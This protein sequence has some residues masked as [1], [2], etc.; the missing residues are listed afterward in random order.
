MKKTLPAFLIII[1]GLGIGLFFGAT[2][3]SHSVVDKPE[4]GIEL[5]IIISDIAGL[6]ELEE[7]RVHFY[8]AKHVRFLEK[9]GCGTCHPHNTNGTFL[10][11]YPRERVETSR[12]TLMDSYHDSCLG[13]HNARLAEGTNSGPTAC[14]ECH[15]PRGKEDWV[16]PA[17]FDH[18]LHHKHE[19]GM[20]QQCEIC[21]HVF[22]EK[23][24]R[25]EYQKGAE[26]SCRDCHRDI[27]DADIS[28]FRDA[29][30][31][32]C[33]NCHMNKEEAGEKTGPVACIGCHGEDEG[34]SIEA[35]AKIPRP[36]RGQPETILM[37]RADSSMPG[38]SFNHKIH[39]NNTN[40]CRTCHHETLSACDQ[41]HT[42]KGSIE[43]GGVTLVDAFHKQTSISSCIGCHNSMKEDALC[44][45][46]HDPM[47]DTSMSENNCSTC[48]TGSLERANIAENMNHG[49]DL[50]S[51]LPGDDIMIDVLEESYE[52]SRFPHSMVVG[53]LLEIS[54]NNS[55]ANTFHKDDLT[56]CRGCH[57]YSSPDHADKPPLCRSCHTIDFNPENLS[58]PRLLASYHLQCLGC[59]EKMHIDAVGCTSC[60]AAKGSN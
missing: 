56:T 8:H 32:G 38:V 27:G 41:C 54:H 3:E 53:K 58:K 18:L 59:H 23:E 11:T 55:L 37:H 43:G 20:N 36:D 21:H 2:K 1:T 17:G 12:R 5:P 42:P 4:A 9:E 30:H 52:P 19:T 40:T 46:C 35:L 10:F 33:V 49:G 47:K 28:S 22:N 6:N 31:S 50:L 26:S 16:Q 45:G 15:A 7:R 44:A 39:E 48:H 51:A 34:R 57:H 29:A 25:L 24:A 14:G 13:C 60:H